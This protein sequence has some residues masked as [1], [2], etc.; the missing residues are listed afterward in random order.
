MRLSPQSWALEAG[1]L[2]RGEDLGVQAAVDF[3]GG[4]VVV[5]TDEHSLQGTLSVPLASKWDPGLIRLVS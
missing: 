1:S 5:L 3:E 4:H 2:H